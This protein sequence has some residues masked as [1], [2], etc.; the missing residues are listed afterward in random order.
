MNGGKPT[1]QKPHQEIL[2]SPLP[3]IYYYQN[4][5]LQVKESQYLI[6]TYNWTI[7]P[8]P[9]WTCSVV[10]I[11]PFQCTTPNTWLTNRCSDPSTWLDHQLEK[12]VG[13][14]V[15]LF[16]TRWRSWS[17]LVTKPYDVQTQQLL[18]EK[19]ELGKTRFPFTLFFTLMDLCSCATASPFTAFKIIFIYVYGCKK[20][21]PKH[22]FTDWM[23]INSEKLNFINL[24]RYPICRA[25]IKPRAETALLNLD[26]Y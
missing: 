22:T 21:K 24:D 6:P 20:R 18:Q 26:R 8:I 12:D 23:K 11:S 3:K 25:A 2:R 4:K 15:L 17:C 1:R 10:T 5:R 14:K 19:E 16:I 7:T 9:N 13:C